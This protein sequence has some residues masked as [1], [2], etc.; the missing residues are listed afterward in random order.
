LTGDP[1]LHLLVGG[2]RLGATSRHGAAYLF[3]LPARPA[4]VRIVSRAGA[5]AELGLARDPR[6]LGV[7]V[8]RIAVRQGTRFHVLE[9]ADASLAEGFR[10]FELDNGL[11]WTDGDAALPEALFEGFDGPMELVLHVGGTTS[12]LADYPIQRVA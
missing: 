11:R 9:A 6:V 3:R 8:R 12:Y 4:A 2:D 1:D 7:A 5:P 10:E